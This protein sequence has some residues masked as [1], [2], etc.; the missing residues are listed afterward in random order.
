[1]VDG[2][3]KRKCIQTDRPELVEGVKAVA[4]KL[5]YSGS[6][7][8]GSIRTGV[9]YYFSVLSSLAR[10]NAPRL[11]VPAFSRAEVW[12]KVAMASV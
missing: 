9:K 3:V 6:I 8:T 12:L 10:S 4:N 2:L 1:M 5:I 11:V 7:S